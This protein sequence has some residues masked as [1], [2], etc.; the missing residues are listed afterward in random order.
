[1]EI[2]HVLQAMGIDREWAMGTLRFSAGR[3]TT[4]AEIDRARAVVTAAVRKLGS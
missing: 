3:M 4:L 2:S 1:V